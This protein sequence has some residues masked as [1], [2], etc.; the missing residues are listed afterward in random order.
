MLHNMTYDMLY[1]VVYQLS[2]LCSLLSVLFTAAIPC[3]YLRLKYH[4]PPTCNGTRLNLL[5]GK[6][7]QHTRLPKNHCTYYIHTSPIYTCPIPP[8]SFYQD[9]HCRFQ[10]FVKDCGGNARMAPRQLQ[11]RM[12]NHSNKAGSAIGLVWGYKNTL[13][14]AKIIKI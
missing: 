1:D 8:K 4:C 3:I 9:W 5:C 11:S 10:L 12:H 7:E 6:R 14:R 13:C 2:M